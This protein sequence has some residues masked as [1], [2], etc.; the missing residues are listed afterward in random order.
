MSQS[1]EKLATPVSLVIDGILVVGFFA[2]MFSI[3]RSHVPSTDPAMIALWAG[4]AAGCM[5]GVF[6][7]AIQMFRVVLRAQRAAKSSVRKQ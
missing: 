7:L 5:S 6:W 2:F 4:L 1:G 3:L